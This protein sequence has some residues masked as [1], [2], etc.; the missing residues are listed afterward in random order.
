[1][2]GD[3][4]RTLRILTQLLDS[5]KRPV[6][7]RTASESPSYAGQ[8]FWFLG[9]NIALNKDADIARRAKRKDLFVKLVE[10]IATLRGESGCPWDREQTRD[11]VKMNLVEEAYEALDAIDR[12]DPKMLT[13]E[14]GDLLIQVLFHSQISSEMGEFDVGDVL[15]AAVEK[16]IRRHPHVFGGEKVR[17]SKEVLLNWEEIKKSERG[18]QSVLADIPSSLPGF[19]RALVVQDKVG[20]VGF[21]WPDVSGAIAKIREEVLELERAMAANDQSRVCAECGDLLLIAV[22]LGRYLKVNPDD[23][24]REAVQRFERRFKFVEASLKRDGKSPADAT[25]EQM[26]ALWNECKSR[27]PGSEGEK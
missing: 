22:N 9:E 15:S 21:E 23:V 14:L 4:H 27:E 20:R 13:Q 11:S 2:G 6:C 16:L 19:M 7:S 12:S 24:L 26:D 3:E 5:L 10:T 1:M 25:L 18:A 17:D 8:P